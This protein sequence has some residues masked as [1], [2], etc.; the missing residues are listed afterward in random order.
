MDPYLVFKIPFLIFRLILHQTKILLFLIA[1]VFET[2][3]E[4]KL[5]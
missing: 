2:M 1:P 3:S 5:K 4:E